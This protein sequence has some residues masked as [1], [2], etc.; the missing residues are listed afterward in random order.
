MS[1]S[2]FSWLLASCVTTLMPALCACLS[3][4]SSASGEFGT[5]VIAVGR[6]AIRSWMILICFSGLA[7]S[8]P[9]IE[10]LAPVSLA[11]SLMPSFMRSNQP[12]PWSLTTVTIFMS[13]TDLVVLPLPP[14]PPSSP[15][16]PITSTATP[17]AATNISLRILDLLMV[18]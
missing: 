14:P 15:H 12:T 18:S 8:A 16:A 7:S 13:L 6:W 3:T 5:A 1:T 17:T 10:A 9:V 11:N 2:V 4:P